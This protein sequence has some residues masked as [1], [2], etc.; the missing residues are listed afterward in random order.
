MTLRFLLL[1]IAWFALLAAFIAVTINGTG[2]F[3]TVHRILGWGLFVVFAMIA[4][5][6]LLVSPRFNRPYWIGVC[7]FSTGSLLTF[8]LADVMY[9]PTVGWILSDII[10]FPVPEPDNAE[11]I[12]LMRQEQFRSLT[13]LFLA[14]I[15]TLAGGMFGQFIGKPDSQTPTNGG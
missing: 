13:D 7:V 11:P 2:A 3:L 14:T 5:T 12:E 9:Q 1:I 4:I 8:M 10:L 15:L 6:T